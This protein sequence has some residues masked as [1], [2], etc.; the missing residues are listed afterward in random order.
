MKRL[1]VV[2]ALTLAFGCSHVPRTAVMVNPK[3]G[4][5]VVLSKKMSSMTFVPFVGIIPAVTQ[6]EN[7][8]REMESLKAQGYKVKWESK[9]GL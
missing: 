2:V 9:Q 7:Q 4:E 3:T 6:R 1:C 8:Q 5:E